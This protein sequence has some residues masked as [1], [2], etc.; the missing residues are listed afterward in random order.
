MSTPSPALSL[1]TGPGC[2]QT[3][4]VWARQQ[5]W[6]L[7][8]EE[9]AD[10]AEL[11][12]SELVA[13]ALLHGAPPMS[14]RLGGTADH[15]R[16]EVLDGST[17]V[18]MLREPGDPSDWDSLA[19]V[20]RGLSIVARVAE[21]WG[22]DLLDSGKA[23]WFEPSARIREVPSPGHLDHSRPVN[24]GP[25]PSRATHI[26]RLLGLPGVGLG[27]VLRHYGD[28]RREITL[29]ALHHRSDYP[30]AARITD[31]FTSFEALFDGQ[32][33]H[34]VTRAASQPTVDLK[35]PLRIGDG[36]LTVIGTMRDLLALADEFCRTGRLLTVPRSPDLARLQDWLLDEIGRQV[37]GE[38]AR[39]W[40]G[41]SPA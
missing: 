10:N 30:L 29:L 24:A 26:V 18:P 3:A 35:L 9:L 37:R 23:V 15:P 28:L 19:T 8:R 31:G 22:T 20:G 32:V 17:R 39:A 12:I 16:F 5:C 41:G 21:V 25:A 33:K 38:A 11:A 14:A 40:T 6:A 4:R 2:A 34:D 27:Q 7:G 1:G 13:N 36:D